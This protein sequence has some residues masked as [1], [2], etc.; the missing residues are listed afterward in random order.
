MK[1][2]VLGFWGVGIVLTEVD[3]AVGVDHGIYH[4]TEAGYL[5]TV[6]Q[7]T[8]IKLMPLRL[9]LIENAT[10]DR[11]THTGYRID[12]IVADQPMPFTGQVHF[13][14]GRDNQAIGV[15]H[16]IGKEKQAIDIMALVQQCLYELQS[17]ARSL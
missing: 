1:V 9:L 7:G 16:T 13:V 12:F 14:L 2:N 8:G 3:D 4:L 10:L 15:M 6:Q 17:R 5:G 11:R